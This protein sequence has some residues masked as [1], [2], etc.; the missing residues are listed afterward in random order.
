MLKSADKIA[1]EAL[2]SHGRNNLRRRCG[3]AALLWWLFGVGVGSLFP[4]LVVG[5]GR[6]VVCSLQL[7]SSGRRFLKAFGKIT[8]LV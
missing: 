3:G 7:W 8:V 1:E 6:V 5:C 4:W 2:Q